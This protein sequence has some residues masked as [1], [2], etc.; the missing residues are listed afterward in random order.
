MGSHGFAVLIVKSLEAR[1]LLRVGLVVLGLVA[2][3]SGG[4]GH[5]GE[6]QAVLVVELGTDGV[7]VLELVDFVLLIGVQVALY[8]LISQTSIFHA[9]CHYWDFLSEAIE[10]K[11]VR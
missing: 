7:F 10:N 6:E 11:L 5:I 2:L 3:L 4:R 9:V 8:F 1:P